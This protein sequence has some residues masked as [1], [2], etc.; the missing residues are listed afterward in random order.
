MRIKGQAVKLGDNINTDFIISGRYK[1]SITDIKELSKHIME[2]IDKDFPGKITPGKSIIVAGRNFGMG[3][4][5][6]QAP[7]VIKES[8]IIAVLAKTFARIFYRNGFNVGLALIETDTQEIAE[9]DILDIDLDKGRV[10]DLS[11]KIELRI[12]PLPQFMQ[13]ILRAGGIVNYYKK[14]RKLPE[15]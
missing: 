9:N 15:V 7:L 1:F 13:E 11:K 2:D 5:R 6:E 3:S 4:S 14:H 10:L 12:K 8:G